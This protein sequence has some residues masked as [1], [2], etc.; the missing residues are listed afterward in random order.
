MRAAEAHHAAVQGPAP[1]A[2]ALDE[3]GAVRAGELRD[4]GRW[5][6]DRERAQVS[7]RRGRRDR[8]EPEDREH[9]GSAHPADPSAPESG[10]YQSATCRMARPRLCHAVT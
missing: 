6:G 7:G 3:H 1:R 10:R 5:P 2:E 9:G 4:G 8:E